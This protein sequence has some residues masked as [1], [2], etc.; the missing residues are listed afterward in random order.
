MKG[1][2]YKPTGKNKKTKKKQ[3]MDSQI[4]DHKETDQHVN[5]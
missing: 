4:Q 3:R 1:N 5:Q 2:L